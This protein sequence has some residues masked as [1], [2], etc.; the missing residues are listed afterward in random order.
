[1]VLDLVGNFYGVERKV[2]IIF[3]QEAIFR[4]NAEDAFFHS[5]FFY[6][7]HPFGVCVISFHLPSC[8]ERVKA[9]V[10]YHWGRK[11]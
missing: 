4:F 7:F 6:P 5:S 8:P 9:K 10:K 3:D 11:V 1:M 2:L